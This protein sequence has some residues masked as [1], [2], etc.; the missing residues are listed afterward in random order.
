M[1]SVQTCTRPGGSTVQGKVHEKKY[2]QMYKYTL[3]QRQ[4][5]Q[6]QGVRVK[7]QVKAQVQASIG[8]TVQVQ[9]KTWG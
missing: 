7:A 8:Y 1:H 2:K 5:A 9:Y 3:T 6:V 4:V